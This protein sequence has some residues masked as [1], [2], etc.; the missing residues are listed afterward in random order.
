MATDIP[1]TGGLVDKSYGSNTASKIDQPEWTFSNNGFGLLEGTYKIYYKHNNV[2]PSTIPKKGDSH[3]CDQRLKLYDSSVSFQR[4][5]IC[6]FEGKY[7][8]I[9]VGDKTT[10]E[11]TISASTTEQ[12]IVLHPK[13]ADFCAKSVPPYVYGGP[14]NAPTMV[15]LD[16]NMKFKAFGPAHPLVPAVETFVVP[17]GNCKV[18]CYF[19]DQNW[20]KYATKELGNYTQMP[21]WNANSALNISGYNLSW[22]L[23]GTSVSQ[24]GNLY[25]VELDFTSSI[26]GKPVNKYMYDQLST[27]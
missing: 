8:G 20:A 12:P 3:P 23:T 19:N 16:E 22:M 7:I 9:E 11:F 1:K 14:Y 21:P 5:N 17:Q 13:F 26:L 27:S 2:V 25:K 24:Y 4:N 15:V 10:P 18:S 6:Y